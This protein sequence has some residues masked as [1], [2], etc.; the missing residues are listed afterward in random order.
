[1]PPTNP[2]AAGNHVMVVDSAL[3]SKLGMRSDHTDAAI[4]TPDAKPKSN[5]RTQSFMPPR[6]KNTI[7]APIMVP[8][9]GNDRIGYILL[10]II[11]LS[12]YFSCLIALLDNV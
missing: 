6:S 9:N 1:M 10:L 3:I 8:M 12:H 11:G 4:I 7:A 5:L 2:T